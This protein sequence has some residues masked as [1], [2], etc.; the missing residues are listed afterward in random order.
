MLLASVQVVRVGALL[1]LSAQ[2]IPAVKSAIVLHVW[3][4]C[5]VTVLGACMSQHGALFS[6]SRIM[7]AGFFTTCS[8]MLLKQ[9]VL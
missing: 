7:K 9:L 3:L 6:C 4:C 5:R 2:H 1:V 8:T